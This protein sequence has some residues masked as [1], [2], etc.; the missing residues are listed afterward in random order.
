MSV[1]IRPYC[2]GGWEA[3]IRI[4]RPNGSV[5]R[6]RIKVPVTGKAAALRWAEAREQVLVVK[7]KVRGRLLTVAPTVTVPTLREFAPRFVEGYAKANQQKPSG[8]AGKETILRVHLIPQ[9]GDKPL[10]EIRNEHV[11][12]VKADLRSKAPKTVNNVLTVLGVLLKTAVSWGRDRT[13]AVPHQLATHAKVRGELPRLRRVRTACAGSGGGRGHSITA[14]LARWASWTPL[15]R[16]DGA[17]V[18][19]CRS[20]QEADDRRPV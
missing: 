11:Q 4:R 8:I 12:Q 1:K 20:G 13:T 6:E 15:R 2:N 5:D 14:G 7:G 3:D 10:T 16:N 19:G 9:L 18:A 17:G